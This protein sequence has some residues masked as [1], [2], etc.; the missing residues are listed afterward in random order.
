MAAQAGK[1]VAL[2]I[3]DGGSPSEQ[4]V[5]LAGL[6]VTSLRLDQAIIDAADVTST[7]WQT[8]QIASGLKALELQAEGVFED[9]A[10]EAL[11]RAQAF[12]GNH[13]NYQLHFGNGDYL[14]GAFMVKRYERSGE[15]ADVERYT[16][17]LVNA[18]AISFVP[19]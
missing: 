1:L 18:G 5:S 17:S 14:E 2:K 8:H 7:G 3:G 4:F 11:L 13:T 16:V 10:S 15:V 9:S 6:T 12:S 19:S